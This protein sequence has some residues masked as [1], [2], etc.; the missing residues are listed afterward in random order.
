MF[1]LIPL[2][3]RIAGIAL[4]AILAGLFFYD[5]GKISAAQE[6]L[7]QIAQLK[8]KIDAAD[9]S[10]R[11]IIKKQQENA[12]ATEQENIDRIARIHAYYD[13]LLHPGSA[14]GASP[15]ALRP[16]GTDAAGSKQAAAGCSAEFEQACLLDAN[17]VGEWQR[18]AERNQLPV[19]KD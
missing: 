11:A 8:A 9:L 3:Y 5:R 14:T 7:P 12:H 4:C 6:Y 17:K 16:G 15:F 10:A 18:W 19:M 2:P 1:S 13:R